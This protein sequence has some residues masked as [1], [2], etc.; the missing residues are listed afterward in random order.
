MIKGTSK[1][2]RKY[3]TILEKTNLRKNKKNRI[4]SIRKLL[5]ES[6]YQLAKSNID[7][8]I[9]EYGYD[10]YIIHEYGKYYSGQLLFEP[11]KSYFSINIENKSD[12]IYYSLYELAKIE[13][14]TCNYNKA[15]NYLLEI[16]NSKHPDKSHAILELAKIYN[17][18]ENYE[19]AELQIKEILNNSTNNTVKEGAYQ[20]L[21][22]IKIN[23]KE[24]KEAEELLE[25]FKGKITNLKNTFLLGQLEN[26]KGNKLKAYQIFNNILKNNNEC[27]LKA[28]YE[29]AILE[30]ETNHLDRALELLNLI[31]ERRNV[32]YNESLESKINCLIQMGNF[33]S[34]S[35]CNNELLDNTKNMNMFNFYNAKIE[36]SKKNY[37]EALS[38]LETISKDNL[39]IYKQMLY[40]KICILI[41]KERYKEAYDTFIILKEYDCNKNY[42]NKY[43]S[44]EK[45]LKDKLNQSCDIEPESY[46]EKL[47]FNYDYNQVINHIQKHKEENNNKLNH[48]IFNSNIDIESLYNYVLDNLNDDNFVINSFIDVYIL[49]YPNVGSDNNK[50]L[51]YLK[52]I[53]LPNSKKIITM[54]PYDKYVN[55]SYIKPKNE[56]TKTLSRIDKFNKKYNM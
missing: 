21:I 53:T 41:K 36:I 9:E 17:S 30:M 19:V 37:D 32:Q 46:V 20:L 48:T 6:K 49:E 2:I 26:K 14:S 35:E 40:K 34:A 56:K 24:F 11:A 1:Q 18:L 27:K 38:L 54:Y 42:E 12:N 4:L 50:I 5:D 10:C 15:I 33:I 28:A 3:G 22:Q 51:N 8:Y 47:L 13:K 43:N 39:R 7:K 16:I 23:N 29:L 52:V 55:E 44:L 31:L 45:Y 25:K